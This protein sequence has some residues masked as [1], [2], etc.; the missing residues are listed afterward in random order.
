LQPQPGDWEHCFK[1]SFLKAVI[2]AKLII[3]SATINFSSDAWSY[4]NHNNNTCVCEHADPMILINICQQI[5]SDPMILCQQIIVLTILKMNLGATTQAHLVLQVKI[6]SFSS[7]GITAPVSS[8]Y[9]PPPFNVISLTKPMYFQNSKHSYD[10]WSTIQPTMDEHMNWWAHREEL[11]MVVLVHQTEAL[12]NWRWIN[13]SKCFSC[14][15][16]INQRLYINIKGFVCEVRSPFS[17]SSSAKN[18]RYV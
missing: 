6:R 4:Y 18:F 3:E 16:L 13:N 5:S 15:F 14:V 9:N 8:S 2:S 17:I 10:L 11:E 1:F 12:K 7:S